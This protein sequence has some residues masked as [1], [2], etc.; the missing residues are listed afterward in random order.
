VG[1]RSLLCRHRDCE[2]EIPLYP[3]YRFFNRDYRVFGCGGM[4]FSE[5]NL[6]S[7]AL[8]PACLMSRT[9]TQPFWRLRSYCWWMAIQK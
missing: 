5:A 9:R 1:S 6:K 4:A 2:L 7:F 3:P 8:V